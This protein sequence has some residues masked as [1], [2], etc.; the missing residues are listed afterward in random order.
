LAST[1][2]FIVALSVGSEARWLQ[3]IGVP[4]ALTTA[5]RPAGP[6]VKPGP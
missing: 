2:T 3:A 5:M 6:Q 4:G 1:V